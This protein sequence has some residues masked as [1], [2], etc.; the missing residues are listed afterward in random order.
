L[1][2]F[3]TKNKVEILYEP[4]GNFIAGNFLYNLEKFSKLKVNLDLCHLGMAVENN[5]LGMDLDEF[6][7]K[8]RKRVVYIHASA[9]IK[10]GEHYGIDKGKL[11][12]RKVLDQLD[13]SK[14]KK[15]IIEL[16][17]FEDFKETKKT[18]DRYLRSRR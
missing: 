11:D 4:N 16:H 15:I 9:Y 7:K 17:H 13:F 1:L 12:W 3:A 10:K 6:L 5:T 2:K 14:I 8:I 18:L